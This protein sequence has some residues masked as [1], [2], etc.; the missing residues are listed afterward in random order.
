[1]DLD[2]VALSF[3]LLALEARSAVPKGRRRAELTLATKRLHFRIACS[4]RPVI[5]EHI[6][7]ATAHNPMLSYCVRSIARDT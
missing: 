6:E 1:L 2:F 5:V 7:L 3:G 4:L